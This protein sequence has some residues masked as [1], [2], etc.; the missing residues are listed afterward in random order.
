MRLA[1]DFG[2]LFATSPG[3]RCWWRKN[4]PP[5]SAGKRAQVVLG[6]GIPR[7]ALPADKTQFFATEAKSVAKKTIRTE[8]DQP[9]AAYGLSSKPVNR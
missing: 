7:G 6:A 2:E 9:D 3:F 8:P 1:P 4:R 5:A